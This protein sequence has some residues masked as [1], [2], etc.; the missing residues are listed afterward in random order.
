MGQGIPFLICTS[1]ASAD[2]P[3]S[4]VAKRSVTLERGGAT[5]WCERDGRDGPRISYKRVSTT[6]SLVLSPCTPGAVVTRA[7]KTSFLSQDASAQ[8][9][10]LSAARGKR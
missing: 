1:V 7:R 6:M 3:A 4:R 8:A 9:L 2:T 10:S 5:R